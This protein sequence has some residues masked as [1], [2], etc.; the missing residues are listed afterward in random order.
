MWVEQPLTAA[1]KAAKKEMKR[2]Q[3]EAKKNPKDKK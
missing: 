3:R 2:K 1:L